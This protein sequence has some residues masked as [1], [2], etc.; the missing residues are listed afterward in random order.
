MDV[1]ET[2]V[3]LKRDAPTPEFE[4]LD[5]PPVKFKQATPSAAEI[6]DGSSER[7]KSTI[8]LANG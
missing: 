3:E 2:P 8:L 7:G 5:N 6:E 4:E 1:D